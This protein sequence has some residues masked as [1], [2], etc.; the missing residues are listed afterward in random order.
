MIETIILSDNPVCI[1][2]GS[3][4]GVYLVSAKLWV[5]K[6]VQN[7]QDAAAI[8]HEYDACR[9]LFQC[10]NNNSFFAVPRALALNV[11]RIDDT[12]ATFLMPPQLSPRLQASR[13]PIRHI[14]REGEFSPFDK[15]AY[16]L[17]RVHDLPTGVKA[18]LRQC[19]F[20]SSVTVGPSLCRL[21]FGKEVPISTQPP[22]FINS[23]N[24]PLD[25]RRYEAL[26][27]K[28]PEDLDPV[29][30]VA[31]GMG[32]MLGRIHAWAS[33]DGRDIEFVL[34]GNGFSSFSFWV[35]D[36]NQMR[37]WTKQDSDIETLTSAFF[38]NDPYY[39]RPRSSDALY[40][41]FK[42][43][44]LSAF[45]GDLVPWGNAFLAAIED[46]A[47]SG[48]SYSNSGFSSALGFDRHGWFPGYRGANA[49][50]APLYCTTLLVPV[51]ISQEFGL[52]QLQDDSQATFG[53]D[54]HGTIVR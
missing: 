45:S 25:V 40:A 3:F 47:S 37:K 20:P 24:F 1:G 46:E 21:Y 33:Y 4:A 35:I 18:Y 26:F 43:G 14:V 51:G 48:F 27:E 11:P 41:T 54:L 52:E 31:E 6:V 39:P 30:K 5:F 13:R 36:F 17:D 34:G 44:Y 49:S 38:S 19:Y 29:E 7:A 10:C 12:C 23:Q 22:R 9:T 50:P 15:A 2:R 53:T 42:T 32:E 8:S 16:A 28:F